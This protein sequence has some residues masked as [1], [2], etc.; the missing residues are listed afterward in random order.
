MTFFSLSLAL[1]II[2]VQCRGVNWSVYKE[3][4]KE[5]ASAK[6]T[7]SAVAVKDYSGNHEAIE[8]GKE[9]FANTCAPVIM[10]MPKG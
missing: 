2:N 8:D 3:F 5:M 7:E 4:D 6:K 1:A 10:V 9:I